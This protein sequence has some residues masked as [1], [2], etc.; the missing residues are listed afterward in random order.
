MKNKSKGFTIIELIIALALTVLTLGV[1][2]T[3]FFSSNRTLTTT[4]LGLILQSDAEVIQKEILEIASQSKEIVMIN[5]KKSEDIKYSSLDNENKLDIRNLQLKSYDDTYNK[6]ILYNFEYKNNE[7]KLQDEFGNDIKVLSKN[8]QEFKIRPIDVHMVDDK[9][10][11]KF[12]ESVGLEFTVVL[13]K[14]KVYAEA[15]NTINIIT[16]FRNKNN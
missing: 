7:L 5:E 10:K 15:N 16:K 6:N 13:G 4:E 8:V 11:A 1:I 14:K 9:S 3:F 12:S 2:Y